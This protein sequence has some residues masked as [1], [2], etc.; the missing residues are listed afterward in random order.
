MLLTGA[1]L[2]L[3][4][5]VLQVAVYVYTRNVISAAAAQGARAGAAFGAEPADGGARAQELIGSGLTAQVARDV[6]CTGTVNTEA[7]SGLALSTVR[8]T[9]RLRLLF[10]PLP[11]PLAVDVSAS[12][13][14]EQQP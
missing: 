13:L 1:L 3:L 10:V 2:F 11:M 9:G 4:F 12:V 8:C 6:P 5:A 14:R 7:S